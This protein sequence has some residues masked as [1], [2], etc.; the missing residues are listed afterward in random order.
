MKK[1][2]YNPH[3]QSETELRF[4]VSKPRTDGFMIMSVDTVHE[5]LQ[6]ASGYVQFTIAGVDIPDKIIDII[7]HVLANFNV[8]LDFGSL[9][10]SQWIK[11]NTVLFRYT[12]IGDTSHVNMTDIIDQILDESDLAFKYVY[13]TIN[14]HHISGHA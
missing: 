13:D 14:S 5:S 3:F 2:G 11:K 4:K 10:M 6:G 1:K 9:I 12:L 8:L 7:H